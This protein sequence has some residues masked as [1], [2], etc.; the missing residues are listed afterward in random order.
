VRVGI[1]T[2]LLGSSGIVLALLALIGALGLYQI[3]L[4]T[5]ALHDVADDEVAG[6][7][8]VF[9]VRGASLAIQRDLR[10]LVIA[11]TP[12]E[13]Q[14]LTVSQEAMDATV[15]AQMGVLD[16]ALGAGDERQA[17]EKLQA[18]QTAWNGVRTTITEAALGGDQ[19][20]SRMQLNGD[21]NRQIV[22]DLNEQIANL[23][24][25]KQERMAA[26]V[27]ARDSSVAMART[28]MLGAVALSLLVGFGVALA[29][30]RSITRSVKTVQTTLT[31]MADDDVSS[32]ERGL[33]AMAAGDLTVAAVAQTQQISRYGADEVGQTAHVT[34][35]V[36]DKMAATIASYEE[37][38]TRLATLVGSVQTAANSVA[39]S[40][41]G[42]SH[43]S[44]QA[45][46]LVGHVAG[47][48][49]HLA[50]GS[51]ETSRAAT[52]SHDAVSQ[53]AQA[54][55]GIAQGASSQAQQ[56]QHVALTATA[57]ASG[58]DQVAS[59]AREVAEAGAVTRA[60]AQHGAAAVRETV[61]GMLEIRSVVADAATKVE[62]LGRLGEKIGA[63]VETIDD[64]AEQT[65]LLALN[66]AIEAARA[67]EHGRGFAVVADE[68][69]KLAER[70]QRETK[71]IAGL[72][73]EVQAGTRDAVLAME[74]GS[75]KVEQ[76]T[77]KA[78]QA[79]AALTD[80]LEAIEAMV[81][82]VSAIAAAAQDMTASSQDVMDAMAN[83]S[84]IV[85]ESSAATEEMAAQAGQVSV[86]MQSIASVA[87]ESSAAS[88]EAS[89]S[90]D[91]MAVQVADV[92]E[93]A[94]VL[95]RTAAELQALLGQFRIA[96]TEARDTVAPD[97]QAD[98]RLVVARRRDDWGR[99]E[100]PRA[101]RGGR[102]AS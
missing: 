11:F 82:R 52:S 93:Q 64:I 90:S 99:S 4:A 1:R 95:A 70:S 71:A 86:S 96:D 83:I 89:A 65:N 55:D 80:I 74:S 62:Q 30:A 9:E 63:V 44:G 33:A 27:A 39:E 21:E 5:R 97:A 13:K 56:I 2:K 87:E 18:A 77:V 47:S 75:G 50:L 31:Q 26:V 101:A 53:L 69:R 92:S 22:N 12:D 88:R 17:F 38:R 85:E 60:S 14:R 79:G 58:V 23:V 59:D 94:V 102:R 49:Q 41:T 19:L 54:I 68:V 76:G 28:L 3:G 48:V 51:Q 34:N 29:M 40:S 20:T 35:T 7:T 15:V 37:A 91:E 98:E 57:M 6:L 61:S 36:L 66:A 45:G 32:I 67:G 8:A 24:R 46:T 72:I 100:R 25:L 81:E 84:A 43:V 42:L 16:A 78:D 10:Q 73:R